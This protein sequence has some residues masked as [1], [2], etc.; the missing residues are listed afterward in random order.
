MR[1]TIIAKTRVYGPGPT[2]GVRILI[3]VPGDEID[4][5]L[6]RQL[7]LLGD[8]PAPKLAKKTAVKKVETKPAPSGRASYPTRTKKA[9]GK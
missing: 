8:E 4:V 5:E 3:A 7:G 6:A 1:N 2:P 9:S